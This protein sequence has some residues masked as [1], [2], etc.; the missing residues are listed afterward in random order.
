MNSKK[1]FFIAREYTLIDDFG[2]IRI[3]EEAIFPTFKLAKKFLGSLEDKDATDKDCILYRTEIVEYKLDNTDTY[4][5]KYTY[6]IKGELIEELG[7]LND[8]SEPIQHECIYKYKIGDIVFVLPKIKNKYSPSTN[9]AYGVIVEVPTEHSEKENDF[10]Y[11]IYYITENGFLDHCHA[12]E[13]TITTPDVTLPNKLRF[14]YL[15]SKYLRKEGTLTDTL[16]SEIINKDIFVKNIKRF[17]FSKNSI[18]DSYNLATE[19]KDTT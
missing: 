16:I 19:S 17:D 2:G 6:S 3:D 7:K 5:R 4:E 11:T 15:Y 18:I 8:N 1:T 12:I 10:E 13:Q 14:L 9:G